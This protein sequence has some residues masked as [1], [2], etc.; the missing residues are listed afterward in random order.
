MR[1]QSELCLIST[2]SRRSFR[3][4]LEGIVVESDDR[5]GKYTK[6]M[7]ERK[8]EV[9]PRPSCVYQVIEKVVFAIGL[10]F[11]LS[12]YIVIGRT[13]FA[14]WKLI[15][16]Q[17][18]FDGFMTAIVLGAYLYITG[19]A[20]PN[21][22]TRL[23]SLVSGLFCCNY[24]ATLAQKTAPV[25]ATLLTLFTL[26]TTGFSWGPNKQISED[27][28]NGWLQT[29]MLTTAPASVVLLTTSIV[30]I[31]AD[32][33]LEHYVVWLKD[34]DARGDMKLKWKYDDYIQALDK[35]S[36]FEYAKFLTVISANHLDDISPK[37][38]GL[39]GRLGVYLR[40]SEETH[41][42]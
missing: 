16:D 19:V 2:G 11:L 25:M 18:F 7:L 40:A 1:A 5:P 29:V 37:A 21:A 17:K 27:Y 8:V 30:L 10:V 4:R 14:G 20:I 38:S 9:I 31:V 34:E 36:V 28:F 6:E 26:L 23:F 15:W 42:L 41:L 3:E 13:G 39:V 32:I 12:Q 22:A 33:V 24:Q 35:C